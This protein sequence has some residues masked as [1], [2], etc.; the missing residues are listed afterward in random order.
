VFSLVLHTVGDEN[1]GRHRGPAYNG[2]GGQLALRQD[3]PSAGAVSNTNGPFLPL[4]GNESTI[5]MSALETSKRALS[6]RSA[7][8]SQQRHVKCRIQTL[9]KNQI[10]RKMKFITS[11]TMFWRMMQMIVDTEDPTDRDQFIRVYKSCVVGSL[12]TKRSTCEQAGSRIVFELLN[13][14]KYDDEDGRPVYTVDTLCRLRQSSSPHEKEAFFWFI[15]KFVEAVSGRRV[16]GRKKYYSKVSEASEKGTNEA[17]VTVSDEAFAILLYENYIA[18]WI[19]RFVNKNTPGYI[20]K[21][22]GRYTSSPQGNCE[23]GGWTIEG[24]T[25]FNTLCRMVKADR[26]SENSS[27]METEV[28]NSIRREKFGENHQQTSGVNNSENG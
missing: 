5:P 17:L 25:R 4:H 18:K 14:K 26:R 27:A 23:Y 22:K 11:E 13:D 7:S 28:M 8:G 21:V 24:V 16:W 2:Q 12:N 6:Y 1:G 9:V 20:S 3:S 15:G 10:F 19:D